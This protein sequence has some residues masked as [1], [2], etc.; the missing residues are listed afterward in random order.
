[1]KILIVD[2]DQ[3]SQI[4]LRATLAPYGQCVCA[5][6][7]R[8]GVDLFTLALDEGKPFSVVF[9]DIQMPVMDGH[10]ALAAIRELERS[11]GVPPGQEAKAVMITCHDDVKNVATSF[12]RGNVT[13][14]FTKPLHL[15]AMVETLKKESVL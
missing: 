14:Y 6:N 12:F 10:A 11:R 8:E 1:M 4:T 7:G 13:C 15:A 3:L 9:M 2:D 5:G